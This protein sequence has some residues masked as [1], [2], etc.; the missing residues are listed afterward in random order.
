MALKWWPIALVSVPIILIWCWLD[1]W[2]LYSIVF[3][4]L[5][6]LL[7]WWRYGEVKDLLQDLMNIL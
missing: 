1:G 2:P 6:V 4:A 7:I 5:F 3:V